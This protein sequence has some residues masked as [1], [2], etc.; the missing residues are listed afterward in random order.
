MDE[1]RA[2]LSARER[3]LAVGADRL[4]LVA[5]LRR[6]RLDVV[7]VE[8]RPERRQVGLRAVG[9][10]LGPRLRSLLLGGRL[11]GFG[12][13]LVGLVVGLCRLLLGV[14]GVLLGLLLLLVGLLEVLLR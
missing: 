9:D 7:A 13:R 1:W 6:L 8:Q 11:V 5:D 4:E 3:G 2:W 10:D 14:G 12:L